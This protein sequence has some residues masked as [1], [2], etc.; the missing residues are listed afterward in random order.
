[1][2]LLLTAM[3][4]NPV[5]VNSQDVV[6]G[7]RSIDLI[8]DDECQRAFDIR[9]L[10]DEYGHGSVLNMRSGKVPVYVRESLEEIF[11]MSSRK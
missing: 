8:D 3:D 4:G 7:T 2:L 9:G 11:R 1:M 5:L 6:V 10:V